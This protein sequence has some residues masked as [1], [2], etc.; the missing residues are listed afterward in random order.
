MRIKIKHMMMISNRNDDT[1]SSVKRPK[2][3]FLNKIQIYLPI[4]GKI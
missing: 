3:H 2:Y 4:Y 1:N